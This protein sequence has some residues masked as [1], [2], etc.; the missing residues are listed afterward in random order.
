MTGEQRLLA[1]A[2]LRRVSRE[3]LL[4]GLRMRHP[5]ES[6]EGLQER[7]RRIMLGDELFERAY[8]RRRTHP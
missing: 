4:A 7:L 1:A 2:R 6:D 8:G 5:D 3:L